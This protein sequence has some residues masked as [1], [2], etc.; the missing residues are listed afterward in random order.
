MPNAA[1][2]EPKES[3]PW[4]EKH[5]VLLWTGLCVGVLLLGWILLRTLR[6]MKT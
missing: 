4:T 5:P 2:K 3:R 6:E 1:F